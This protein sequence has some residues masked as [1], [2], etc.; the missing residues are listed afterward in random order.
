MFSIKLAYK[1]CEGGLE[2]TL[3]ITPGKCSEENL[4]DPSSLRIRVLKRVDLLLFTLKGA[5]CC[6]LLDPACK[7]AFCLGS[8][9][10]WILFG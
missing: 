4:S 9:G 1:V 5:P 10:D 2:S 3:S 7:S 8:E 6:A